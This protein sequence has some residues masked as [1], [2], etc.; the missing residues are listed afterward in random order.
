MRSVFF[1]PADKFL[2]SL[3]FADQIAVS[4]ERVRVM[5]RHKRPVQ[6]ILLFA[7]SKHTLHFFPTIAHHRDHLHLRYCQDDRSYKGSITHTCSA[8]NSSSHS[9][10][11]ISPTMAVDH[12]LSRPHD[13]RSDGDEAP[14]FLLAHHHPLQCTSHPASVRLARL[15]R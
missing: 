4:T 9:H 14:R 7:R 5:R 10:L 2:P 6:T 3:L 12:S 15:W 8:N 11:C 13:G 1:D